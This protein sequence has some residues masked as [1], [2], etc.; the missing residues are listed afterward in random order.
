VN[1]V[2]TKVRK[3]A[4]AGRPTMRVL[5]AV[6]MDESTEE[7]LKFDME[8]YRKKH[9]AVQFKD[10]VVRHPEYRTFPKLFSVEGSFSEYVTYLNPGRKYPYIITASLTV[11][12][13]AATDEDLKAYA[14]LV[15]SIKAMK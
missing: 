8:T 14:D 7:D 10:I 2:L 9:P 12:G 6:K 13:A 5:V 4:L 3:D 1:L 15:A 11:Q